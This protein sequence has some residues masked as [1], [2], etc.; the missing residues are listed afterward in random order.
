MLVNAPRWFRWPGLLLTLVLAFGLAACQPSLDTSNAPPIVQSTAWHMDN[1]GRATLEDVKTA[2]DWQKFHSIKNWGFGTSPVWIRYSLRAATPDEKEPWIVSIR[3]AFQQN[4][5]LHDPASPLPLK[6]GL[7]QPNKDD[8]LGT[9]HFTFQIPALPYERDVYLRLES[10]RSRILLTDVLPVKEAVKLSQSTEWLLGFLISISATFAIWASI[11]WLLSRELVMGAFAIKQWLAT[12]W[13]LDIMGF[14]RVLLGSLV[15][16]W[17]LETLEPF[18]RMWTIPATLWFLLLLIRDYRP[19]AWA[20]KACQACLVFTLLLPLMQ[21]ADLHMVMNVITNISVTFS[22]VLIFLTLL[23]APQT[24][25]KPPIPRGFFLVYLGLYAIVNSLPPA[26]HLTLIEAHALALK[27]H[28]SHGIMDALVVFILLQFRAKKISAHAQMLLEQNQSINLKLGQAQT[29]MALEQRQRQE[30]SQFLHMLMHEL[31]TPLAIVTL[32]LSNKTNREENLAH[33]SHAVQ[34][35]KA[36]IERCVQS[37]QSGELRLNQQRKAVDVLGFV[38]QQEQAIPKLKERFDLAADPNL[39]RPHTDPQ[40]L[41]IIVTNLLTNAAHYS[42][43]LTP[44]GVNLNPRNR[45]E[46]PGLEL[47]VSNTPG[48]AG[49]PDAEQVFSKYYRASGAQRESG[50]GLGLFLSHELA[51]SLGGTLVYAPSHQ[52]VE[53]V[54]WIPLHP[55]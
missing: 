25:E 8:A 30:Q 53:F 6:A 13:A 9:L 3:P 50:T 38:Q 27:A 48:M 23:T 14:L 31:K 47:R 15:N 20:V 45:D 37:D 41:Q 33:A 46:Q 51:Q 2:Q 26:V 44:V 16:P 52:H 36:I 42:D 5:T 55:A 32:A 43:P 29:D 12:F 1:S 28:L 24:T 10:Q 34:D 11:Q 35:M 7:Y 39:P 54:L 4:L 40:L 21:F 17:V 22:L 49:W 18:I 19:H